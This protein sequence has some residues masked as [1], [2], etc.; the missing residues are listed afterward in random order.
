MKEEECCFILGLI[1]LPGRAESILSRSLLP[2]TDLKGPSASTIKLGGVGGNGEKER[3]G[4]LA[5]SG[6]YL[7]HCWLYD[8]MPLKHYDS[9]M[10]SLVPAAS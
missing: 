9:V 10:D 3:K 1:A 6:A 4:E 7:P 5:G 8:C 2:V